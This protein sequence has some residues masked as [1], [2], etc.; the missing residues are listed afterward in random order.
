M[1][2]IEQIPDNALAVQIFELVDEMEALEH[3][4]KLKKA[5]LLY[6]MKATK[7]PT[8]KT[9][10][11][12]FMRCK[13]K[14][15]TETIP[16]KKQIEKKT[17]RPVTNKREIT[18]SS[19]SG[20]PEGWTRATFIVKEKTLEKLKDLVYTERSQLK[21]TVNEALENYI[22]GKKIIKRGDN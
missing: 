21:I 10:Y 17:G 9:E 11:G 7:M 20:L 15:E 6:S 5:K 22:K 2:Q 12:S 18:K 16:S 8:I 14:P 4:I 19:Q 1:G 13:R 3:E